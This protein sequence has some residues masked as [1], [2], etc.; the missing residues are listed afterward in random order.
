MKKMVCIDKFGW[1]VTQIK[2]RPFTGIE[3][4]APSL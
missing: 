2:G 3:R 1:P 4:K